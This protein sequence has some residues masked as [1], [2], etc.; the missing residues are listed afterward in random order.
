MV[1]PYVLRIALL[2]NYRS[3]H[4]IQAPVR[5]P[6]PGSLTCIEPE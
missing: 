3:A 4:N 5:E 6:E 2:R 1:V